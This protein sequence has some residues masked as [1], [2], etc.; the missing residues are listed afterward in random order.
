MKRFPAEARLGY[1]FSQTLSLDKR[2]T[3]LL[4]K[5]ETYDRLELSSCGAHEWLMI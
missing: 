1:A 5:N 3:P 2:A 4:P